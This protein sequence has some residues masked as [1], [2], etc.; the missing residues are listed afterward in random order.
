M[1][2][3]LKRDR[4]PL[5]DECT[6]D[7]HTIDGGASAGAVAIWTADGAMRWVGYGGV[8]GWSQW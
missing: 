7:R 5:D 4:D 1:L 8:V 6:Q 2:A 3:H